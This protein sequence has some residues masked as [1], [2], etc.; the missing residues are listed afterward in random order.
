MGV[1]LF[2]VLKNMYTL[3]SFW[4]QLSEQNGIYNFIKYFY[5]FLNGKVGGHLAFGLMRHSDGGGLFVVENEGPA[6]Y[7]ENC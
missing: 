7:S 4:L 5:D 1:G 2:L 6:S 3:T